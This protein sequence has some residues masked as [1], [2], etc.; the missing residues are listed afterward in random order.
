MFWKRRAFT[1][2]APNLCQKQKL[3][4]KKTVEGGNEVVC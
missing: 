2:I 1:R 4:G 3:E